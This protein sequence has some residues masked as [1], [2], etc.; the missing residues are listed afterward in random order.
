[1]FEYELMNIKTQARDIYY[2]YND[3]NVYTR[4]NISKD[5]WIILTKNYVD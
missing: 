1:M 2:G 4:N 5:E 3:N